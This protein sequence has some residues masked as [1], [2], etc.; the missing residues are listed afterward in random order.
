TAADPGRA[1]GRGV[2]GIIDGTGASV[3]AVDRA[4][5]VRAVRQLLA[6][7]SRA[8]LRRDR[9]AFLSTVDPSAARLRAR[10]AAFFDNLAEVPL[11]S[12]S[13]QLDPD[14]ETLLPPGVAEA[15]GEDAWAP[16]LRLSFALAGYDTAPTSQEQ[17]H[18]FVR[19]DGRWLLAD[20]GLAPG[21]KTSTGTVRNLWDFGPVRVL[22]TPTVLVAGHPGSEALMRTVLGLAEQAVPRVDAVWDGG[23]GRRVVVLVPSSGHELG[24]LVEETGDL[25]QMAAFTSADVPHS[26][27]PVGKR[28]LV[29]PT[30]F[31]KLSPFGQRVV[32]THEITH[33]ATRHVTSE[34]TPYWLAEGFADFVAYRDTG[35]TPRRAAR[36]LARDVAAGTLPERLPE[37]S[38]FAVS[39]PRLA[40]AYQEAWL[41]CRL[42]VELTGEATLVRLYRRLS[43]AG[44][45][46]SAALDVALRDELDMGT[47]EF[48]E[49]WRR[50]LKDQLTRR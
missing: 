2:A 35:A 5:R 14:A 33:V 13:Y 12:W 15:Y 27:P 34:H 37:W 48:L 46:P 29:N 45:D 22:S 39:N 50:Y 16:G 20:D 6:T 4:E 36:E 38:D 28:V 3:P 41:A 17:R 7:R 43:R 11:R 24:R 42:I 21:Q 9:A 47:A 19:S 8:I 49:T 26:G 18:L 31:G 40:Q 23:W 25:S 30:V 44:G 10:Q 1:Q 32:L